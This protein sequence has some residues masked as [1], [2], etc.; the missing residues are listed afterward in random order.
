MKKFLL[1]SGLAALVISSSVNASYAADLGGFN[2]LQNMQQIPQIQ[3][4]F[5]DMNQLQDEYR[6]K[7]NSFNEFQNFEEQKK[8]RQEQIQKEN[9]RQ[10]YLEERAVRTKTNKQFVNDNGIIKIESV[11]Y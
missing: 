9:E 11:G 6:A 2:N 3:N 4:P 7:V 10:Q 1:L 5:Y 8:A